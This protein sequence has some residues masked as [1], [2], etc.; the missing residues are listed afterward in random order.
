[1]DSESHI[2]TIRFSFSMLA[3]GGRVPNHFKETKAN[4]EK[5]FMKSYIDLVSG[6]T[7]RDEKKSFYKMEDFKTSKNE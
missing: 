6:V 2:S 7:F 5:V 1:M 4:G 3:N